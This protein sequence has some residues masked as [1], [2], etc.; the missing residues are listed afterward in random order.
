MLP[1]P[2]A[3]LPTHW[4]PLPLNPR[5]VIFF[6]ALFPAGSDGG[7]FL[8]VAWLP[9]DL[10][11]VSL[12]GWVHAFPSSCLDADVSQTFPSGGRISSATLPQPCVSLPILLKEI[13]LFFSSSIYQTA[14]EKNA[15][16]A[17]KTD[18]YFINSL[19]YLT[20]RC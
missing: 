4:T 17:F 7:F 12:I 16:K 19:S 14:L 20:T 9:P 13:L 5:N 2:I 18:V 11:V 1:A 6:F 10:W 15:E 8:S 3:M